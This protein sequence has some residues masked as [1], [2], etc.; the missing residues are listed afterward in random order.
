MITGE[1]YSAKK[2]H[3]MKI[4]VI[5]SPKILKPILARIFK[6]KINKK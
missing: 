6:L 4:V 2:E 5:H 3:I 1:K